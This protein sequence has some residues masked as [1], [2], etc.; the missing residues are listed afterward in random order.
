MSQNHYRNRT[1]TPTDTIALA[2][3]TVLVWATAIKILFEL[4]G[5][6]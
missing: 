1:I 6:I 3:T 5:I 4:F 2:L